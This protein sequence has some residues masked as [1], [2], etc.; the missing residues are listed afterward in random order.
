MA[1]SKFLEVHFG[2][3]GCAYNQVAEEDQMGYSTLKPWQEIGESKVIY[4]VM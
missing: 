4:D 2:K 3:I 1:F